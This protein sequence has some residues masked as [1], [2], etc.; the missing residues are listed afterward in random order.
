MKDHCYYLARSLRVPTRPFNRSS[1]NRRVFRKFEDIEI[2][3]QMFEKNDFQWDNTTLS[4]CRNYA[5][6]RFSTS[7]T[8]E[9]LQTII[10]HD[11]GNRVLTFTHENQL[12]GLVLLG[13]DDQAWHYWFAFFSLDQFTDL[14]FGKWAMTYALDLA[15][16]HEIGHV[17]LGTCYGRHSLYKVRDFKGV[18]FFDGNIWSEDIKALKAL[19]KSDENLDAL[20]LIKKDHDVYHY[21]K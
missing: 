18:S 6:E 12:V 11:H 19:C 16:E 4:F 2:Q 7:F 20:D 17:Y 10:H 21:I 1:E 9:R 3:H 5:N 14:P 13:T 15:A 8:E